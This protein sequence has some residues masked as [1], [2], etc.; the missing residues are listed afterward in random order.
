MNMIKQNNDSYLTFF[1]NQTLCVLY[2]EEQNKDKK[3]AKDFAEEIGE[4]VADILNAKK[5]FKGM[6]SDGN[7]HE[8]EKSDKKR[9]KA[10]GSNNAFKN[11]NSNPK[12]FIISIRKEEDENESNII[13]IDVYFKKFDEKSLRN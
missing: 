11:L 1:D 7:D 4:Q 2:L 6:A 10:D 3:N 5:T 12:N 8:E 13:A 9:K